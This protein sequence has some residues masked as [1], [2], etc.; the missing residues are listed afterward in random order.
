M[1]HPTTFTAPAGANLAQRNS[2]PFFPAFSERFPAA[3]SRI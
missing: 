1:R 2:W 3:R